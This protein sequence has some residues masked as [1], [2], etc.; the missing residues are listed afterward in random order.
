MTMP[1][2]KNH[3]AL[4]EEAAQRAAAAQHENYDSDDDDDDYLASLN[5]P[6]SASSSEQQQQ[7]QQQY[8]HQ[9][10]YQQQQQQ[11]YQQTQHQHY[12]QN[13]QQLGN[14]NSMLSPRHPTDTNVSSHY[15][16]NNTMSSADMTT[17]RTQSTPSATSNSNNINTAASARKEWRQHGSGA[18]Q[19]LEEKRRASVHTGP[20]QWTVRVVQAQKRVDFAGSNYTA[21]VVQ[22][23]QQQQN[24]QHSQQNQQQNQQPIETLL[25][26]RYSDFAK[27]HSI[28]AQHEQH[29]LHLQFDKSVAFPSKHWAGRV[30]NWTPSLTWA[31]ERHSD[32]I[33]YRIKQLDIWLVH[34]TAVYNQGELPDPI[35]AALYD[36]L[37]APDRPPCEHV[38]DM[39]GL[40]DQWKWNNPF[41]FTLGSSV[42]Q[43]TYTVDYMCHNVLTAKEQSIPLD[44]LHAARGLCF[45]TVFKAGLVVSGRVGTGL[46]IARLN[47][48]S[49][50]APCA[51][52]TVGMGWGAL[53]GGDVTHYLVVLTTDQAVQDFVASSSVQLGAELGVAVGPVGRGANSHIS[54]GDWT[55]HPAYAYAH[56][57]G[58]FVG[59]S[60]EG[61]VVTVR[62]DVNAKFYGRACEPVDLLQQSGPKAAEPLYQALDKAMRIDIPDDAFRPS[63]LWSPQVA[64]LATPR[65]GGGGGHSSSSNQS[66]FSDSHSRP[67]SAITIDTMQSGPG[68]LFDQATPST[69]VQ[70]NINDNN[71]NYNNDY[72]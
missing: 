63:Y 31:P 50:S 52:G 16:N 62:N 36:F 23:Q 1:A 30:G 47:D 69:V 35:A 8:Q 9:Q 72:R 7:Y 21:Y 66:S 70:G 18:T 13:Q 3:Q 42:R 27:L 65:V 68:A 57:Q 19:V 39:K 67:A 46:V 45:M 2:G 38:N 33:N 26:H 43:A 54:A 49:W 24:Q 12:Q 48:D 29:S 71:Y 11:Q 15:H 17:R 4:R 22:V 58:L 32:L 44:L 14:N 55:L 64:S 20:G 59:M 61:S 25:E 41:S 60:L 34:L 56:S 53:I 10:Q 37:T 28:V 5:R 40:Q 51:L 6:S